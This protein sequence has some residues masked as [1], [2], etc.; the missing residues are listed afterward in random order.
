MERQC[1]LFL[2]PRSLFCCDVVIAGSSAVICYG[3]L[4]KA[5]FHLE[6]YLFHE[7]KV[8]DGQ[9]SCFPAVCIPLLCY[10]LSDVYV[11]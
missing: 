7:N 9:D 8:S 1:S 11:V 5:E 4:G 3:P 10:A 6:I 2:S